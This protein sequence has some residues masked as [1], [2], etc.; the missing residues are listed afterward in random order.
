M[1]LAAVGHYFLF[2]DFLSGRSHR[3]RPILKKG[4]VNKIKS[5]ILRP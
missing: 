5:P 3:R 1:A 4:E 2:L